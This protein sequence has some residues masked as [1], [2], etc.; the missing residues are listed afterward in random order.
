MGRSIH[1]RV[2]GVSDGS[3]QKLLGG[4]KRCLGAETEDLGH[5]GFGGP[6]S[7]EIGSPTRSHKGVVFSPIQ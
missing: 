2:E 4:G 3:A 5:H 1:L 7:P 6:G